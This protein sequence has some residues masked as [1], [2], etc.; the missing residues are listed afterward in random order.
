MEY[1]LFEEIEKFNNWAINIYNNISQDEIGGEWE[2]DYTEWDKIY[3]EFKIFTQETNPNEW[4]NDI[5]EKIIYIIARDNEMEY[6][7]R[8]IPEEHLIILTKHSLKNGIINA[9]WQLLTQLYKLSDRKLALKFLE[10]FIKDKDEYVIRRTLIE[11]AKLKSD[12]TEYYCE[13][14]WNKNIFG[15]MEEYQRIAVLCALKEIN[16]KKL[17]E[18]IKKAKEDGRK[19]LVENAEKIEDN[20]NN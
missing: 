13:K 2:C 15:E 4:T 9:K 16:S 14:I 19:Y 17:L 1:K 20:Y 6:L 10:I 18:Y 11:M 7:A 3:K 12:K 5:K 8:N